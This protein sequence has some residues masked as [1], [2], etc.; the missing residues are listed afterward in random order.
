MCPY[1]S[2]SAQMSNL[3][4]GL[5]M[6]IHILLHILLHRRMWHFSYHPCGRL[7][8]AV[9]FLS[10]CLSRNSLFVNSVTFTYLITS[11]FFRCAD[12]SLIILQHLH[13]GQDCLLCD[14]TS[15][16]QHLSKL[17]SDGGAVSPEA[18][19]QLVQSHKPASCA[20]N[21]PNKVI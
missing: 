1:F 12:E 13:L 20:Q 5:G 2:E 7:S 14:E 4:T 21:T 9:G 10:V 6:F 19:R 8:V 16:V 3:L 15:S 17:R 18:Q 11:D